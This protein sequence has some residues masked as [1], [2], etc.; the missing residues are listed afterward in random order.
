MSLT[1]TKFVYSILV[2]IISVYLFL[3]Y[4]GIYF[5]YFTCTQTVVHM[6]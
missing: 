6:C 5:V 1:D 2:D 4:Y 3:Y